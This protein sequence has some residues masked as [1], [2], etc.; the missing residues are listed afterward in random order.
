M[1]FVKYDYDI[2]GGIKNVVSNGETAEYIY[3]SAGAVSEFKYGNGL[4]TAYEYDSLNRLTRLAGFDKKGR[5][6]GL[7]FFL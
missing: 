2:N 7:K 5:I 4:K 1:N 3:N 6:E